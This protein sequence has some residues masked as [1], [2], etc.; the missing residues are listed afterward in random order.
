[1]AAVARGRHSLLHANASSVVN[2]HDNWNALAHALRHRAERFKLRE[3]AIELLDVTARFAE[4]DCDD[5]L[6][7]AQ[8]FLVVA[9][10]VSAGGGV[11]TA[12]VL[13][14]LPQSEKKTGR[15]TVRDAC[16]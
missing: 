7:Y 2:G 1:M 12:G 11:N 14:E 8:S 5:N 16:Q 15:Q 13:L 9:L 3:Y 4:P 10:D 6:L